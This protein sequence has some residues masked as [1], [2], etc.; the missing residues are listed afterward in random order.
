MESSGGGHKE[1]TAG[2]SLRTDSLY[3][4]G[5]NFS[6]WTHKTCLPYALEQSC[7]GRR[8]SPSSVIIGLPP[9]RAIV[10]FVVMGDAGCSTHLD[11]AKSLLSQVYSSKK[12]LVGPCRMDVIQIYHLPFQK[13]G[14]ASANFFPDSLV[15]TTFHPNGKSLGFVTRARC[16]PKAPS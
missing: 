2:K 13:I 1:V 15:D 10:I 7:A 9:I 12:Y 3:S 14:E 6:T 4:V 11:L 8:S 5:D 16:A